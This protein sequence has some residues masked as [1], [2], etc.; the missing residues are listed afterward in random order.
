M[1]LRARFGSPYL[2][3]LTYHRVFEAPADYPYDRGVID[4]GPEEFDAQLKTLKRY[5][6]IVGI[7][8]VTAHFEGEQALPRNAAMVTFDDGYLDNL[9]VA[10]PILKANDMRAV[11]FIATSYIEE[12]RVYWWDRI[13]Y[14]FHHAKPGVGQITLQYPTRL[15]LNLAHDRSGAMASLLQLMK[16]QFDLD[17]ERML[18]ELAT[19]LGVHW[20]RELEKQ[21]CDGFV[22]TW[23][24]VRALRKMGMDVQSHTRS[25][26]ALQT[27]PHAELASELAGAKADLERELGEPVVSISYPIGRSLASLD[28]IAQALRDAGYKVGF[29]NASGPQPLWNRDCYDV[30]RIAVDPEYRGSFFRGILAVPQLGY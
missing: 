22:M 5:F 23:D 26:R 3:V 28:P 8:E 25:H 10:A 2:T 17:V 1:R 18:T 12:R 11:F 19:A 16:T 20:D 6:N 21:L 14:L 29:T 13:H 30:R 4:V 7:E 15:Q 27:V 9:E 24:D